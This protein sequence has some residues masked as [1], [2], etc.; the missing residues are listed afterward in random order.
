MISPQI[1]SPRVPRRLLLAG[2][3][4]GV[5]WVVSGVILQTLTGSVANTALLGAVLPALTPGTI[6]LWP[7]GWIWAGLGVGAFAVAS[8][9]VA[10]S[11]RFL[12]AW[13]AVIVAATLVGAVTDL[14]RVLV[15]L[16]GLLLRSTLSVSDPGSF[17]A[18]GAYWGVLYGWV[19]SLVLGRSAAPLEPGSRPADLEAPDTPQL[20]G[21]RRSPRRRRTSPIVVSIGVSVIMVFAYLAALVVGGTAFHA[22]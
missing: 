16:D 7:G 19:A 22:A 14:A 2:L 9:T 15:L 8:V 6:W 18:T 3:A 5:L 12:P 11:Y 10:I 1:V 17:A 4:A 21:A 20:V 13:I